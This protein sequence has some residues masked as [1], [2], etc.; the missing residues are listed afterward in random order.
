M[1]HKHHETARISAGNEL[2]GVPEEGDKLHESKK[3]L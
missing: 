2:S 1:S 3:R